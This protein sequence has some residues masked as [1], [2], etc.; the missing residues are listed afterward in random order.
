MPGA[1]AS[2]LQ[3]VADP[4]RWAVLR[5]LADG[6]AC[7]CRIQ[8]EAAPG[9]AS[10]LLSYHLRALRDAGLVTT[11]RRGRWVDYSLADDAG[12]RIANAL[13]VPGPRREDG[14]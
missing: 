10:N 8:E 12:E 9:L 11:S 6:P 3:T 5:L 1:A 13:P 4:T 7:V 2:L 14:A